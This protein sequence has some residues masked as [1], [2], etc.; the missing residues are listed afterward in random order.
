[1]LIQEDMARQLS[2]EIKINLGDRSTKYFYV[3]FNEK[4]SRNNIGTVTDMEG[5]PQSFP[6]SIEHVVVD[7]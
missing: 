7:Y 5:T 2:K 3:A 6:S 1:M 4:R